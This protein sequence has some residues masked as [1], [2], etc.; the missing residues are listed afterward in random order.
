MQNT[1]TP[2][3]EDQFVMIVLPNDRST[4]TFKRETGTF[5]FWPRVR[6]FPDTN[7]TLVCVQWLLLS[8]LQSS[9]DD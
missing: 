1:A 5:A 4:S 6:P 8:Q 3:G 7:R 2:Y 9:M